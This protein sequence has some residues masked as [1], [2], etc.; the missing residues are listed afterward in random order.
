MEIGVK[1]NN[2][3]FG[4]LVKIIDETDF[5]CGQRGYIVRKIDRDLYQVR[6]IRHENFKL[7]EDVWTR[8]VLLEI[9]C[10][11][12]TEQLKIVDI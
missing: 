2:I 6:I 12:N 1:M 4:Q 11:F 9:T 5:Y 10:T 8:P 7:E 3:K